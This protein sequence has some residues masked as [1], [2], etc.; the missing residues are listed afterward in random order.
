MVLCYECAAREYLKDQ[1]R[2]RHAE[3]AGFAKCNKCGAKRFCMRYVEQPD[4]KE[5]VNESNNQ[6]VPAENQLLP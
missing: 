4:V 1:S 3:S 5:S 6:G 2:D